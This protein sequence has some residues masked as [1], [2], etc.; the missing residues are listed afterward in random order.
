[1][2]KSIFA[3][4]I[5][6]VLGISAIGCK[7]GEKGV[8]GGPRPAN[9]ES[10]VYEDNFE[11][12]FFCDLPPS[13]LT[14]AELQRYVEAGFNSF[15]VVPFAG[16]DALYTV[17]NQ[18]QFAAA[19]SMLSEYDLS[20]YVRSFYDAGDDPDGSFTMF[21][22]GEF[23]FTEYPA[24][25]GFYILDEPSATVFDSIAANH[26][27]HFN[28]NYKDYAKW[29]L[30]LFPS[31]ATPQQLGT[32][33]EGGR[34]AYENYV[35]QYCEKVLSKVEGARAIG[36]DHYPMNISAGEKFVSDTFLY[37]LMITAQAA[38]E[39]D[40]VH[41]TCIQT[42]SNVGA[43][44]R[45][46]TSSNEIRFLFNT[47]LAFGVS[48]FEVFGYESFE[49]K[50]YCTCMVSG[51]TPTDTYSYVQEAIGELK[52]Y[53]HVI[54]SFEWEGLKAFVGANGENTGGIALL[55]STSYELPALSGVKSV[56]CTEDTIVGQ[57]KDGDDKGFMVVNY[58]DPAVTK[59]DTVTLT[60]EDCDKVV[61]YRGGKELKYT[62][63]K[64]TLTLPLIPGEG[65]FVIPQ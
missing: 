1:M 44:R 9:F 18:S 38:K 63:D 12:T 41:H 51:G 39:Y 59:S 53:D 26:V 22:E 14:P 24:F 7:E 29:H 25:E 21:R 50:G 4:L 27:V 58:T 3:L 52:S 5:A 46:F 42:Y 56:Q 54:G 15:I 8:S 6:L 40:A 13:S 28:E 61:V 23:D 36:M 65:V 11:F 48:R 49:E 35:K 19:L 33:T 60:F 2:K 31:Y 55:N 30:N 43:G 45:E 32:K 16:Y 62:I 37:D 57:F 20:L 47:A 34:S 10:K 64:D 17:E